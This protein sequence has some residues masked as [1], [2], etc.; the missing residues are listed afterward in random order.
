[1]R[2]KHSM[3]IYDELRDGTERAIDSSTDNKSWKKNQW[4]FYGLET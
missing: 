3:E 4:T 1:M 2:A